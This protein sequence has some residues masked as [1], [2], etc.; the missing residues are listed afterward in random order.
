MLN[1]NHYIYSDGNNDK[2][3]I[4]LNHMILIQKKS[5]PSD[6]GIKGICE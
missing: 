6:T 1:Q 5:L 3:M 2:Q 4:L